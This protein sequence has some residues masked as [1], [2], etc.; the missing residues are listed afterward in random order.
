MGSKSILRERKGN[1]AVGTKIKESR[2]TMKPNLL[3]LVADQILWIRRK[4]N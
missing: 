1:I 3:N 2:E 4:R